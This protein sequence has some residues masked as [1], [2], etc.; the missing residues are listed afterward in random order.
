VQQ[1]EEGGAAT[2]SASDGQL[3]VPPHLRVSAQG[4][5]PMSPSRLRA[6]LGDIESITKE[7]TRMYPS[8]TIHTPISLAPDWRELAMREGDG[9]EVHLL[10]SRSANRVKVTVADSRN[11]TDFEI[12]VAGADALAAF[13][14]PFAHASST[15]FGSVERA[16][17]TLDLPTQA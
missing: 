5:A 11:G 13:N 15:R 8:H 12:D 16:G 4:R 1:A 3:T 6:R 14:H 9:I 2:V 10:W 17:E 7:A